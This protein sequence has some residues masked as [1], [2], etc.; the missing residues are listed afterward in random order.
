MRRL[1]RRERAKMERFMNS[2]GVEYD[3]DEQDTLAM[4]A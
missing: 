4:A 1:D 3:E 2:L